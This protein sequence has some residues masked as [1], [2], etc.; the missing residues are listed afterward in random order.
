VRPTPAAAIALRF[1]NW[2]RVI[3]NCY[4]PFF[5][6][7]LRAFCLV[8]FAAGSVLETARVGA[9]ESRAAVSAGFAGISARVKRGRRSSRIASW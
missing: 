8:G 2:R 6:F 7:D 9:F 1:R 4:L 3:A 5:R